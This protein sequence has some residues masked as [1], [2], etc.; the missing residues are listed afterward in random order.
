MMTENKDNEA[1]KERLY[2]LK[3]RILTLEWDK[4]HNQL[5]PGMEYKYEE[6]K[7]E[8]AQI[9][10]NLKELDNEVLGP[11]NITEISE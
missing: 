9:E 8:C 7:K 3:K 11:E 2:Y 5:N 1:L 6:F 4:N 10:S